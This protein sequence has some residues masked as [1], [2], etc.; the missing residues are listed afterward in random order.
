VTARTKRSLRRITL[1][2]LL[3]VGGA[4]GDGRVRPEIA[5]AFDE[6]HLVAEPRTSVEGAVRMF[7]DNNGAAEHELV[8]A[9]A[10]NPGL[11]PRAADGSVDLTKAN[12]VDRLDKVGPGRYRI[13]PDLLPGTM[14]LF[15][16]LVAPGADGVA[17]SH[18]DR[19]MAATINIT[20]DQRSATTLLNP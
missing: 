5:L 4:C 19:G 12:I 7:L 8:I 11:L 13:S 3:V 15:C 14:V 16:N 18:F 2:A 6:Y 1:V 20:R 17:V 9:R 10:D